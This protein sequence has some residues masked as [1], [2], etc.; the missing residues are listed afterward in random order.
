MLCQLDPLPYAICFYA[1]GVRLVTEGS[2]VLERLQ[3]LE[4]LGVRLS[5][6][7]TCLDFCG[8]TKK[9]SVGILAGMVD[10]LEAQVRAG[11]VIDLERISP[12]GEANRTG[13]AWPPRFDF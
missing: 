5:V 12:A 2:P 6:C 8:W 4:D 9:R 7:S 3:Q 10:I 1:E 13:T 11:K